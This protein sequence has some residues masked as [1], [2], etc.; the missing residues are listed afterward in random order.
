MVDQEYSLEKF[1]L[2]KDAKDKFEKE[3]LEADFII[4]K[5]CEKKPNKV[6]GLFFCKNRDYICTFAKLYGEVAQLVRASDS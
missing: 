3:S 2:A 1:F 4:V 5:P 6:V